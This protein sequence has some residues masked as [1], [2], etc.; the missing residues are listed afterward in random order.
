V[1][2]G[3]AE[4]RNAGGSVVGCLPAPHGGDDAGRDPDQDA[5][6]ERQA[7]ELERQRDPGDDRLAHRQAAAVGAEVAPESQAGPLDVL[8]GQRIVEPVLV[9][10]RREHLRVAVLGRVRER[11]IAGKRA[12]PGEDD[13]A[14]QEDDDQGGS[15]LAPDEA[16]HDRRLTLGHV[17]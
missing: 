2:H 4:Q 10:D 15:D 7:G 8:D 3:Q 1:R 12:H 17:T 6:Q 14:R 5:D 9:A 16:S 11:G 13:H